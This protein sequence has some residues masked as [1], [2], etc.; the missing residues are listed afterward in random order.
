MDIKHISTTIR[1]AIS[2]DV[3]QL[4]IQGIEPKISVILV[5]DDEAS[6]MYANTKKKV[7]E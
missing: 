7:A 4:K 2:Q 5:G 6:L 3:I 1:D